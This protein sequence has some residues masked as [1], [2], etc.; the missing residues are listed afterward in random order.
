MLLCFPAKRSFTSKRTFSES[1]GV[2]T[3]DCAAPA[4]APDRNTAEKGGG[5][6]C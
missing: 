6:A 1:I 2:A 5:M 3:N 4:N